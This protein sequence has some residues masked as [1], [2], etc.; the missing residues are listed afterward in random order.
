M[1][2]NWSNCDRDG[3][4]EKIQMCCRY[5]ES[6][7]TDY[8]ATTP[9]SL[10]SCSSGALL[11]ALCGSFVTVSVLFEVNVFSEI[12]SPESSNSRES[13]YFEWTDFEISRPLKQHQQ[14]VR[15]TDLV[16]RTDHIFKVAL[17]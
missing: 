17:L 9:S 8:P 10:S 7:T 12:R 6:I 13:G 15:I 4:F 1:G 3:A 16:G 14:A 2:Q 5:S 11:V